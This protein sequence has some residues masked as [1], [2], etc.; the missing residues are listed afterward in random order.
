A[1]LE[2]AAFGSATQ[3]SNPLSYGRMTER[4]SERAII[5]SRRREWQS[6][7]SGVSGGLASGRAGGHGGADGA[8][9]RLW[10][11]GDEPRRRDVSR[12]ADGGAGLGA[13]A[14]PGRDQRADVA[15]D[16]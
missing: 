7:C 5:A 16:A 4:C 3:R 14:E 9:G 13:E 8:D 6:A 2:P 15:T 12:D 10:W 11:R 1:G